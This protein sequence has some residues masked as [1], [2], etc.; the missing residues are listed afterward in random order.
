MSEHANYD[1]SKHENGTKNPIN[2]SD[3]RKLIFQILITFSL[4]IG[5]IFLPFIFL[6]PSSFSWFPY[7]K[8][9]SIIVVALFLLSSIVYANLK[10]K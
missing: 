5:P 7:A 10:S 4:V 2:G 8:E 1:T 3:E 9:S 6:F